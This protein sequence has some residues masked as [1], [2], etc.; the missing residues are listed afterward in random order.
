MSYKDEYA[1]LIEG[2]FF[3]LE[4][5]IMADIIRRIK[6][7][8]EITSTAD[9]QA[10]RLYDLLGFSSEEIE[11]SIKETLGASYP[12]IFEL[13][14]RVVDEEY[15]RNKTIYEQIN[16]TFVPYKGNQQLQQWVEAAKRQTAGEL[17]NITATM[18]FASSING[19]MTFLP[20]T[21]FYKKT[22]DAAVM[23]I[24]SG[25]FDYNSTLKRAVREMTNSG[26][27]WVD[28]ASG[29]HNRITV[30]A[31]RAVMTGASQLTAQITEMNAEK[32]G[33]EYFEIDWHSG[34]RP[35]HAEWQ[36][37]VWS[38]EELVTV[39]G[40]GTVTGLNGANCYH[41][42]YPFIPGISQRKYTDEWLAEQNRLENIPRTFKGKDYTAYEATQ[43]QRGMET[44]MRAQREKIRGLEDGGADPDEI[45]LQKCR[46]QGQ[47]QEYAAFSRAMGIKERRDRIYIDGLG[48][49]VSGKKPRINPLKGGKTSKISAKKATKGL[50]AKIGG[51]GFIPLHEEPVLL[52][53][54]NHG[55]K[56]AVQKELKNFEKNAIT[57]PVETACVVTKNGEVYKCFGSEGRVFPDYDLK[58]K[59]KGASVSH[60]HTINETAFSF[61]KDDLQL[62]M[63]YD[64]DVLR[65]CDEKYTYEFNRNP[66]EID[67]P[68]EDWMNF[69]NYNHV[70]IIRLAKEY[71]IG[72]R[73]W[74][75]E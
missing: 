66:A 27:R 69:E 5:R 13:Y 35:S 38:R 46:Y 67:E 6:K 52:K 60:N 70:N 71:G 10:W 7:A 30:A 15:T 1:D 47:L 17:A 28:Y 75:N 48:N 36:G 74:K 58:G 3:D 59:L 40:K 63:E 62:F 54:I 4:N 56:K 57:E 23:D 9:Y 14:D 19:Q 32:L 43:K 33:T 37:K 18:G 31:R 22:L 16:G 64:L 20:L 72:Y 29:W 65:G 49:V 8:G 24:T 42:Y 50:G 21:D 44:A 2:Q 73:R 34:A 26:V 12:E 25:A 39:C 61:S 55:G 11:G 68:M 41:V 53:K 45:L 51:E